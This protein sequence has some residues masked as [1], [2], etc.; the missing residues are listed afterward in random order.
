MRKQDKHIFS[1]AIVVAG[2]SALV[3]VWRQHDEQKRN[4][5]KFNWDNFDGFRTLKWTAMGA[6]SGGI[7]GNEIYRSKFQKACGKSFSS[8]AFIK[9][10]LKEENVKSNPVKYKVVQTIKTEV[11]ETLYDKFAN[12]LVIFPEDVGSLKKGTALGSCYDADV[13]LAVRK[14]NSFGSL[15]NMSTTIHN[16]IDNLYGR[17]AIVTKMKKATNV[18]FHNLSTPVSIDVVYGRE[19]GNYLADRKLNLYARPDYFWQTGTRFKTDIGIQ[20]LML[21]NKP[22]VR[23]VIKAFK[24][25]FRKNNLVVENVLLDQLVLEAMSQKNYGTDFSVTENILN[26]MDYIIRKMDCSA[27][28]D[29][30]NSNNNLLQKIDL[31]SRTAIIDILSSDL[32]KIGLN[33][34]YLREAFHQ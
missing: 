11:K 21:V 34:H 13:V 33:K 16:T 6:I 20:K 25:Y 26:C 14:Y 30:A 22:K 9:K 15:A 17:K 5:N 23:E 8:D 1:A 31:N 28:R 10:I 4:G 32:N 3:D 24:M 12:E 29:Y 7:V 2:I 19:T 27:I 18:F